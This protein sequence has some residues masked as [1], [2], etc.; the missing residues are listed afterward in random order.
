MR[1]LLEAPSWLL[2]A[3][4]LGCG[5]GAAVGPAGSLPGAEWSSEPRTVVAEFLNAANRRDH[6]AM[7]SR[8]GTAEGPVGERPGALGC[9][10]RRVGSWLR[11][12][13]RCASDA[14]VEVRMDLIAAALAHESYSVVREARVVGKD[15]P[16]W[17]VEVELAAAGRLVAV[18]FLAVLSFGNRWLVE[19]VELKGL[20]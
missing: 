17:L 1:R 20:M 7:A 5:G 15:R 4:L 8:F 11:V 2:L 12:G 14:E 10:L 18:P 3:T 6:W 9:A 16:A 19:K 13:H